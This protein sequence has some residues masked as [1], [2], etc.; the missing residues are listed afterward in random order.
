MYYLEFCKINCAYVLSDYQEHNIHLNYVHYESLVD[1][2]SFFYI[3]IRHIVSTIL[4]NDIF[5]CDSNTMFQCLLEMV[6]HGKNKAEFWKHEKIRF[7]HIYVKKHCLFLHLSNLI[8]FI[9]IYL[10]LIFGDCHKLRFYL[11][12]TLIVVEIYLNS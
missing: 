4:N 8:Y 6:N 9:D 1:K 12:I 5:I 11:Q 2:F 3:N 7:L 10:R